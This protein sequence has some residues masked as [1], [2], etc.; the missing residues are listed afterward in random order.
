MWR[1]S[2]AEAVIFVALLAAMVAVAAA[3]I[4]LA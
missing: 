2:N 4:L 1:M 3:L